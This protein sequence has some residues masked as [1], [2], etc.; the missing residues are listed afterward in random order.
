MAISLVLVNNSRAERA[1]AQLG[2]ALEWGSRG[3]GFKSR[4]PDFVETGTTRRSIL[5]VLCL[6]SRSSKTGRRYV[7]SCEN[8]DERL[9]RHNAGYSKATRHGV[10]WILV[11][12]RALRTAPK[13]RERSGTTNQDEVAMNSTS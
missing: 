8:V 1:V 7:G 4:R 3:R 6:C 11:T 10:P 5:H 2:S 9:R 12:V 13:P